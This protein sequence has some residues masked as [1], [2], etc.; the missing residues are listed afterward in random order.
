MYISI[1]WPSIVTEKVSSLFKPSAY[2]RKEQTKKN[3]ITP[4]TKNPQLIYINP[5]PS[6]FL[7][8][9]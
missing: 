2:H 7:Y 3:T 5:I 8:P 1:Q 9:C 6:Y 4:A